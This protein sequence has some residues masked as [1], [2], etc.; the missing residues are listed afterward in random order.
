M[1]VLLGIA[2][3]VAGFVLRLNPLLVILAAALTTG[4]AGGLG[5]V[6]TVEAFGAAFNNNR[7]ISI[8][9]LVLPAPPKLKIPWFSRKN[10]RFSGK[11]RLNLVRLTCCSSASTCA[12]SV[13]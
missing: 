2:V 12:K 8:V 10:T 5:L 3:V 11:K 6:E 13:L 4:V 9:W 1:W 7:Y